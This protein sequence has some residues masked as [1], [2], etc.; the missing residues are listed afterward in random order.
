MNRLASSRTIAKPAKRVYPVPP[1][2][3]GYL[4]KN[5]RWIDDL[6]TI[7]RFSKSPYY[8]RLPI[9]A[10]GS[11]AGERRKRFVVT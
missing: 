2:H 1:K 9:R 6:R 3:I 10:N 11:V 7:N 8:F 5:P 4:L